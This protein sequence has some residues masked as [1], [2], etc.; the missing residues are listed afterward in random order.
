HFLLSAASATSP[1]DPLLEGYHETVIALAAAMQDTDVRARRGAIDVLESLG[2][3]AAPAAGALVVA[4]ADPDR[5]VRWAAART[6]GKISPV[7]AKSAVPGLVKLLDDP[8]L[9]LRLA[10]AASLDHYGPAARTAVPDL[11]RTVSA[12]DAELRIAAIR[13]LAAVGSPEANMAIP[14]LA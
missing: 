9:D 5:F 13:A 14:A 4:L 6:L 10:A 8:D 12:S 11:I 1:K 7:E 2:A 3:A